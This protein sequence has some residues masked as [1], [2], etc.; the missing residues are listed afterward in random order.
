MQMDTL[1]FSFHQGNILIKKNLKYDV[2]KTQITVKL[3]SC[4]QTQIYWM[5]KYHASLF[6]Y[7]IVQKGLT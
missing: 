7:S 4:V 2:R 3:K 6:L 5:N 1:L